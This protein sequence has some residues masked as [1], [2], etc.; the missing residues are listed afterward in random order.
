VGFLTELEALKRTAGKDFELNII[1]FLEIFEPKEYVDLMLK[2]NLSSF[3]SSF[4]Y[5]IFSRKSID[6]FMDQ[7]FILH[8][9]IIFV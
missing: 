6:I 3:I 8:L 5:R 9:I 7:I 4:S 1:P 2:V